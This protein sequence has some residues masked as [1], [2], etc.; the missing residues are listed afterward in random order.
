[1][2]LRSKK[3][4]GSCEKNHSEFQLNNDTTPIK[5]Q[6][7]DTQKIN[8]LHSRY[9][10]KFWKVH[11]IPKDDSCFFHSLSIE[12]NKSMETI[13]EEI[14]NWNIHHWNDFVQE[15]SFE[16]ITVGQLIK[17]T[18][19]DDDILHMTDDCVKN[20]YFKLFLSDNSM[21]LSDNN[22]MMLTTQI[23]WAGCSEQYAA[24]QLY[25]RTLRIFEGICLHSTT[26]IRCSRLI[27]KAGEIYMR[28]ERNAI[29]K[30]IQSFGKNNSFSDIYMLFH[31]P[32]LHYMLLHPK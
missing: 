7:I 17:M 20:L 15:Q 11:K 30:E 1:M 18:H 21:V 26:R 13:K 22:E 25:N 31:R 8:N 14:I 12:L 32:S 23:P 16:G 4:V 9:E 29:L 6:I 27:S 19:F 5:V 24:S 10:S 28:L 2:L 3:I